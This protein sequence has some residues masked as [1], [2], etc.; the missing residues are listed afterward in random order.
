MLR[1]LLFLK[2]GHGLK[3]TVVASDSLVQDRLLGPAWLVD[4]FPEAPEAVL[5]A[6]VVLTHATWN[7]AGR[8][9]GGP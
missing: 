8:M 3:R 1:Q 4:P 5:R 6:G 7:I 2:L 9:P